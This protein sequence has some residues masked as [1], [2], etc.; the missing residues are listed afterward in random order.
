MVT[1]TRRVVRKVTTRDGVQLVVS[2]TPDGIYLNEYRRRGKFARSLSYSAALQHATQL[3]VDA[4]RAEK[5]RKRR[6]A[7]RGKNA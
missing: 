5:P 1:I 6:K 2:L 7:K 4:M 3:A